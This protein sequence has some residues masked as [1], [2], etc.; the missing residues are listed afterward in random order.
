MN[1]FPKRRLD[2]QVQ[3]ERVQD[4]D[5]YTV[6][7]PDSGKFIRLRE[8]EF[9]LLNLLDGAHSIA[10]IADEFIRTFNLTITPSAVEQFVAS[11]GKLGF[12]EGVEATR[13]EARKSVLL[14]KLKAF[15][16]DAFLDRTYPLVRWLYSPPAVALQILL[17]I[18]G[19]SVFFANLEEFPF[20][21]L[22]ILSAGDVVTIIVALFIVITVHE[23]AHAYACKRYGGGVREMGFLLLYFQPAFY[24][25]LSDAYLFPKKQQ[26]LIV[27]FAGV[28]FQLLLW[29]LFALLWRLTIEGV[30]LNRVFYWTA[31]VCFAT[32]VFNLNPAIKLDGY[33]L[34]ADYLQ[35]PNLRQKAFN[36][37]WTRIKVR[38]FGCVDDTLLH[39]T[40]RERRIYWRYGFL[41]LLYSVALVGF[42]VYRGGQF[43]IGHWHGTGFV[44]FVALCFL[45]FGRPIATSA[46]RLRDVWRERKQVWMKPK[47]IVGYG[48]TLVIVVL[49]AVL[50]QIGQ[51]SGGEARLI[52]AESFVVTRLAPALLESSHYRG[53]VLEKNSAK[54]FQLSASDFAV[55]Q[56]QPLVSV[57]DTVNAGDTLLIINSTLN[58][59]LLAEAESD[60][61]KAEAE[62]RLLLS[63][64]KAEEVSKK[65]SEIKEAEAKYEAARKDFNRVKEQH[66]RQLISESEYE[67]AAAA[68]NVAS[69]VWDTRKSELKLLRSQPKAEEVERSDAEIEKLKSRVQYLT[70]QYNASVILSPFNGVLVGVSETRDLLHL[71]RMDSLVVEVDLDEAD[72][73][74]LSS[75]SNV[76]LRVSAF[77]GVKHH[78]V[79]TKLALA[80]HLK[81][82]ATVPNNSRQ[83]LPEMTGYAKVDCGK[84]SIAGLVWRKISRFF[85]LEFWSWF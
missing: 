58:S 5:Y 29:A 62:R 56:I 2:L 77:P 53:G 47:R 65:R 13:R 41:S 22:S 14:V 72:L 49:L 3:V 51:T 17:I 9:G 82:V 43:L 11:L 19:I 69:S 35:I 39:P 64:P 20:S 81:A 18:I 33:Y 12:L 70:D 68:F 66:T 10:E 54:V 26:R 34:L 27:M 57:G 79:V 80:P 40:A 74:I 28:F 63:D 24:C 8:P 32:L 76:E 84:I 59:G 42:I 73:D 60:L 37:I 7:S 4:I 25:N 71:A 48:V 36:H 46:G 44:L 52:A 83:L 45:I 75:N 1:Q 15:N 16:P 61:R 78:G 31:A 85:R 38:L 50:I 67:R 6:K 23:F 21:L 55:T 30:W